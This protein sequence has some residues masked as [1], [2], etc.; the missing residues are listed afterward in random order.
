MTTAPVLVFE[1]PKNRVT[2]YAD[3]V[4]K[5]FHSG[6][7]TARKARRE[8][9]A[10]QALR[11]LKGVPSILA[12][13]PDRRSVTMS[14]LHGTP[15]SECECVGE[16]TLASL[17]WLVEQMLERG[18]ARHSLPRRDVIVLSDGSA[19]LVD[20]ERSTRRLFPLEPTWLLARAVTRFQTLRLV[21]EFAPQLLTP[22]ESRWLH[23][24]LSFR[25]ALQRPLKLR[26]KVMRFVRARW[27]GT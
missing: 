3:R 6:R 7:G 19:G 14:R 20:F 21:H 8:V 22:G 10:L 1:S 4:E 27:G 11:G 13:G 23:L 9:A 2:L 12:V 16:G 25:A 17:R 24:Q 26:R 18:V 15:L 5:V